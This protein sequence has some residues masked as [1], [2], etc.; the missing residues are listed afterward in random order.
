M[1]SRKR[2]GQLA[3]VLSAAA[4]L[5]GCSPTT[6]PSPDSGQ[7]SPL[8]SKAESTTISSSSS[9]DETTAPDDATTTSADTSAGSTKATGNTSSEKKTTGKTTGKTTDSTSAAKTSAKGTQ[10]IPAGS[11]VSDA[12]ED[13][14][15]VNSLSDTI[16]LSPD[17]EASITEQGAISGKKSL[18]VKTSGQWQRFLTLNRSRAPLK[19]G[20]EY[21]VKFKFK[22]LSGNKIWCFCL[23]DA[24]DKELGFYEFWADTGKWNYG[25]D[26][27]T[28]FSE[29]LSETVCE[30]EFIFEAQKDSFFTLWSNSGDMEALLDDIRISL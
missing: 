22:L 23:R 14:E 7:T 18:R 30:I 17:A 24:E 25:G 26:G 4:L 29:M 9:A 5:A 19:A 28:C 16:Y 20:T 2:L 13:F 1:S 10:T 15:S 12:V 11:F 27:I 6:T 3:A 21:S 8:T